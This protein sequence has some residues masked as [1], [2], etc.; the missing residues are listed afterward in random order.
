MLRRY[1]ALDLGT[2]FFSAKKI[3]SGVF[4]FWEA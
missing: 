3:G 1:L 2:G 4:G